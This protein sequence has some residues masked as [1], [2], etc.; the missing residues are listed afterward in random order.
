[1]KSFVSVLFVSN[2]SINVVHS[3]LNWSHRQNGISGKLFVE[4]LPICFG[5]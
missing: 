5:G 4:K 2:I 1:M 3:R